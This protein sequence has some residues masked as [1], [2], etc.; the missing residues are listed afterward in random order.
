MKTAFSQ[1]LQSY[2]FFYKPRD[3][4]CSFPKRRR[5]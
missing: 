5:G 3:A 4:I 2:A 1:N